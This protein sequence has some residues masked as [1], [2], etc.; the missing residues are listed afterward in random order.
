M[1][2]LKDEIV[3]GGNVDFTGNSLPTAQITSDA[4][5]LMGSTSAPNI[6][7]GTLLAPSAGI[8]YNYSNPTSTTA[9]LQTELANDLAALEGLSGTGLAVRT[10]ADT[11][12]NRTLQAPAAGFTISNPGGVAGDPTFALSDDLAAV[13]ALATTG[14]VSR[15]AS[16]TWATSTVTQYATAVGG[17]SS[18][19]NFVGPGSTGDVLTSQGAGA[20]PVFATIPLTQV[21]SGNAP[22]GAG[23]ATIVL[24]TSKS[25][26]H[27][28]VIQDLQP[29]TNTAYLIMEVSNNGGSSYSSS[30]YL[31]SN[32]Y[33]AYNSTTLTN[34]TLTTAFRLTGPMSNTKNGAMAL[35]I[36]NLNIGSATN[37]S[38]N[39][40]W[41]DT[42]LGTTAIGINGGEGPITGVN[43][44]RFSF[45]SGN[46]AN[47]RFRLYSIN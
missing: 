12:A 27:L 7:K 32:R 2:G 25:T 24:T 23:V 35:F 42:T 26:P 37:L 6:R 11:W 1:A 19:L 43:A 46:I 31:S 47:G 3:Y 44:L 34:N 28:L 21:A 13:E 33:W 40:N 5:F 41:S 17:S 36:Y 38:G 29:V 20:N 4:E 22:G 8:V 45:S 15:T 30:G 10:A 9:Q 39:A 18:G 16:N 14:V